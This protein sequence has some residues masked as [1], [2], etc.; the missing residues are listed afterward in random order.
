MDEINGEKVRDLRHAHELL[1]ASNPP[2]YITIKCNGIS[3]PLVIPSAEVE[4]ANQR[5]MQRNGIFQPQY[6][7]QPKSVSR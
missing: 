3:R 6:L 1:Y 2:A 5:I 7:G 4:A